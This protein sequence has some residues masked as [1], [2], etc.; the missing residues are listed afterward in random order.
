MNAAQTS[1]VRKPT[2]KKKKMQNRQLFIFFLNVEIFHYVDNYYWID[3]F[4]S[5]SKNGL[6]WHEYTPF[7]CC[8]C[9]FLLFCPNMARWS[10]YKESSAPPEHCYCIKSTA[11]KFKAK[12]RFEVSESFIGPGRIFC[13]N[14]SPVI[15]GCVHLLIF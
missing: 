1:K 5:S 15:W 10:I 2:K 4:S 3:V 9:T 8:F 6:C 13:S 7:H 12:F 11:A 14:N